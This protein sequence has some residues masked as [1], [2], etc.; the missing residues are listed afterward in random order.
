MNDE[1]ENVNDEESP[2]F[3]KAA[4]HRKKVSNAS[5][6]N[7]SQRLYNESQIRQFRRLQ[8]MQAYLEMEAKGKFQPKVDKKSREINKMRQKRDGKLANLPIQERYRKV[9]IEKEMKLARMRLEKQEHEME[10]DPDEYMPSFRPNTQV[11]QQTVQGRHTD[12]GEPFDNFLNELGT[13]KMK[14]ENKLAKMKQQKEQSEKLIF[15]HRPFI[16]INSLRIL[17]EKQPFEEQ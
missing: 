8:T 15:T 17:E 9:L 7:A 6:I 12:S 10:K 16:N 2:T 3:L 5:V 1:T 4:S 11:S 14:K 13:W